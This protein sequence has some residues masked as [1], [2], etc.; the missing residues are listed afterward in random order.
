MILLR[1]SGNGTR[2][3]QVFNKTGVA[4]WDGVLQAFGIPAL[5]FDRR[6]GV[7]F[8]VKT[9]TFGCSIYRRLAIIR[10]TSQT[11]SGLLD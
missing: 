3:P 2:L 7:V 6:I 8:C 9:T 4:Q 10:D 1:R 5:D 11:V